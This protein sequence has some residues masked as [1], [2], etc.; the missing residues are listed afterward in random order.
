V[1][2]RAS[3][4]FAA[5]TSVSSAATLVSAASTVRPVVETEGLYAR[6]RVAGVSP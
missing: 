1:L 6:P 3:L 4:V 5:D 2:D